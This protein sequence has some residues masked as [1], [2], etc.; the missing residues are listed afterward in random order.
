MTHSI[1]ARRRHLT[2]P[3]LLLC[4]ALA[5]TACGSEEA[6]PS[7]P[8]APPPAATPT[9][10]ASA[11][12]GP[13]PYVDPGVADGAP[14]EGENNAY[15]RPGEMSPADLKD[16]QAE[17]AR[18]EPVLKRLW[19]RKK[20]DPD[21]VRNALTEELGYEER[22]T[23]GGG[24]LLGGELE[25]RAMYERYENGESVTPEG[26]RIGLY[27]GDHGCVTAFVQETNYEASA[28]GRFPETGC[29]SPPVGH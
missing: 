28:N 19:K 14:H 9:S 18:I 21:S 22:R 26:A 17:T 3:A 24:K 23:T 12:P 29:L 20:W 8:A 5:L 27:V 4:A 25:V 16:A 7:D 6:G 1:P 13:S 2:T 11:A 15:R 10:P